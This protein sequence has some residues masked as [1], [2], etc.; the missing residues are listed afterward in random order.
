LIKLFK[1]ISSSLCASNVVDE[2]ELESP[3]DLVEAF[4]EPLN[5]SFHLDDFLSDGA[6]IEGTAWFARDALLE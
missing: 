2:R 6:K 5:F 4:F 1:D 3:D